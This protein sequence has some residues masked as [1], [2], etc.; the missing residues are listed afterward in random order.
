MAGHN[1]IFNPNL[2]AFIRQ[3]YLAVIVARLE[4]PAPSRCVR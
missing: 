3:M 2:I 1:D 4:K